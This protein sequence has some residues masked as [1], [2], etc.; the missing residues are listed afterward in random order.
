MRDEDRAEDLLP[1]LLR[2]LR[3]SEPFS[4]AIPSLAVFLCFPVDADDDD[5]DAKQLADIVAACAGLTR[6]VLRDW[7]ALGLYN[8]LMDRLLACHPAAVLKRLERLTVELPPE[9]FLFRDKATLSEPP[10]VRTVRT[11]FVAP[12]DAPTAYGMAEISVSLL[13]TVI[14]YMDGVRP[15][16]KTL[17]LGPSLASFVGQ[18]AHAVKLEVALAE[19]IA[20][21]KL[22]ERGCRVVFPAELAVAGLLDA[23]PTFVEVGLM[24]TIVLWESGMWPDLVDNAALPV[25]AGPVEAPAEPALGPA[26]ALEPAPTPV[27]EEKTLNLASAAPET[28][29]PPAAD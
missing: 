4:A 15:E 5:A 6:L 1:R 29:T 23:D 27:L 21:D 18:C 24:T 14:R 13:A 25:V 20:R 26:L 19:R 11:F 3:K 17:V 28:A 7:C 10:Q 16:A 8:G 12:K 9:A 22:A 2:L